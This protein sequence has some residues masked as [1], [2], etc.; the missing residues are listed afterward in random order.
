MKKTLVLLTITAMLL[1]LVACT[2]NSPETES[3][4]DETET[5]TQ[6]PTE[7]SVELSTE[8]TESTTTPTTESTLELPTFN[9]IASIEE[10]VLFEGSGA[11]ITATELNYTNY[12]VELDLLIE[13]NSETALSF[14][15]GSGGYSCN[16]VNGCMT[17]DGYLNCDVAP[18]KKANDTISFDYN[19]LM[20]Y[21]INEIADIEI[22]FEISDD[23]YEH[24]YTGPCQVKTSAYEAHDYTAN[25]YQ[26]A[27][28]NPAIMAAYEYKVNHFADDVRYEVSG[29]RLLSACIVE[30]RDNEL[31]LLLELENTTDTMVSI[32]TSDIAIN[33]LKVCNSTWSSDSINPHKYGFL[34]IELT[35]VLD[36]DYWEAYGIESV[37]SVSLA[38]T[39]KDADGTKITEPESIEIKIPDALGTFDSTGTEVYNN[40]GFRIIA[41]DIMDDPSEYIDDIYL[42]LLAENNSGKTLEIRDVYDSLSVNGFMT[43]FICSNVEL[44]DGESAVLEIQLWGYSLEDNKI[45]SA[46]DITEIEVGLEISEGRNEFDTA[47]VKINFQ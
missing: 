1:A 32:S 31:S 35:S 30:N 22:G 9:K 2:S 18:G 26:A 5:T 34:D 38:L 4:P 43:D 33:G 8:P 24:I 28:T 3:P 11:K 46:S 37:G 42:L 40:G 41:K 13:N 45:A 12:S 21:G 20:L 25:T 10:T 44:K 19:S 15:S 47:T 7:E 27:I 39:Q 23:S 14:I 6:A 29:I 16:S 36:A 17:N